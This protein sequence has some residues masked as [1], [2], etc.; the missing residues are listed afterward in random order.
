MPPSVT[1]VNDTNDALE[2]CCVVKGPSGHLTWLADGET[3][4]EEQNGY[5]FGPDYLRVLGPFTDVCVT[6]TC[7]IIFESDT[8]QESSKV[9]FGCK[10][11]YIG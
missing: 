3:I 1:H 6:Y 5:E 7:Q 8:I 2:I 9:C 11:T 4:A 10:C